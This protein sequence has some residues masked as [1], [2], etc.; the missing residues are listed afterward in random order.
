MKNIYFVRH[1]E[2]EGNVGPILQSFTTP[3]TPKG[4]EQAEYIAERAT[5]LPVEAIISSPMARARETAE[6]ILVKVSKPIEY[7]DLFGERRRPAEIIGQPKD[8][9]RSIE[10]KKIVEENFHLPTYRFSDEENFEDLKSRAKEAL[11]YLAARPEDNVLVVTHG[12]FMRIVLAYVI[13]GEAL[14]SEECVR[15]IHGLNMENT[16]LTILGYDATK[17]SPWWLWVWN[18]HAHLG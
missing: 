5:K 2:S 13:H 12:L 1:G 7:S 18:D 16:G 6:I 14:T 11:A 17:R 8:A 9:P 3:L 10:I 4:R 15:F